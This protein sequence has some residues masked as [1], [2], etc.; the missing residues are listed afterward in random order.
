MGC[1]GGSGGPDNNNGTLSLS[2]FDAPVDA[3]LFVESPLGLT[4]VRGL[5][6]E[7]QVL[8]TVR[9]AVGEELLEVVVALRAVGLH[10]CFDER[11]GIFDDDR[12]FGIVFD[13]FRVRAEDAALAEP[14]VGQITAPIYTIELLGDATM[15]TVRAGGQLVSVKANKEFR[16]EI[17]DTISFSVPTAICHLFDK[18][19]GMRRAATRIGCQS[20][21]E[22]IVNKI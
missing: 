3:H 15:L 17:G 10:E 6:Q 22:V 9:V 21:M 7:E 19:S 18:E 16:A 2:V 11:C 13:C 20:L 4:L 14:G 5:T 1:G 8:L 12:R